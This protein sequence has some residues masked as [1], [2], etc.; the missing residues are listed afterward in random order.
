MGR[1]REVRRSRHSTGKNVRM[2]SWTFSR[3]HSH[4]CLFGWTDSQ[5]I[6]QLF[7]YE[8][9]YARFWTRSDLESTREPALQEMAGR[10]VRL[11]FNGR[12]ERCSLLVYRELLPPQNLIGSQSIP[13]HLCLWIPNPKPYSDTCC[14][15]TRPTITSY[16]VVKRLWYCYNFPLL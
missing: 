4:L 11:R 14:V 12:W 8:Y 6:C 13:V 16:L 15:P 7:I 9:V 3:G 5:R 1:T 2:L 10:R